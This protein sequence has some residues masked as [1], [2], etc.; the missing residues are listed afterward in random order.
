MHIFWIFNIILIHKSLI[1]INEITFDFGLSKEECM[2]GI[3]SY[4]QELLTSG[5]TS[6]EDQWQQQTIS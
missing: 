5:R 6:L 4:Q 3:T 1:R 2:A